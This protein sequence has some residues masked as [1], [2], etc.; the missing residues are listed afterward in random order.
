[1][2]LANLRIRNFRGIAAMDLPLDRHITVIHGDNGAGKTSVL[3][4]I[5]AA[6]WQGISKLH[7]SARFSLGRPDVRQGGAP[8][9]LYVAVSAVADG[10]H[11]FSRTFPGPRGVFRDLG[12]WSDIVTT[13][14]ARRTR[15]YV[16]SVVSGVSRGDLAIEMPIVAYYGTTRAALD[17][18][19][20]ERNFRRE[21]DR[22]GAL[23]HALTAMARFKTV[24]E[25]LGVK[26]AEENAEKVERRDLNYSDPQLAA[27][28]AAIEAAIPRISRLRIAHRPIRL[29]ATYT[30]PG[31]Q[32]QDFEFSQLAGGYQTAVALVADLARRMVQ[33]NPHLGTQSEAI[34]LIDEVD[35]HL[36]PR[37]QAEVMPSLRRAFPNAQFIV[38]THSEQ[39]IT[40][41]Q[42][43]QVVKLST[44]ANGVTWSHPNSTYGAEA[45]RVLQDQMDVPNR[46]TAVQ[47]VLDQYIALIQ[48]GEYNSD[49]ALECRRQLDDWFRGEDPAMV[50]A[51]LEIRRHQILASRAR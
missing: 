5:A 23:E 9:T 50:R 1:M 10:S 38:T 43:E 29:M 40:S 27:V 20:S 46:Q 13:A 32:P 18:P 2:I 34:V 21:F 14:D 4:A 47:Q 15:A 22:L 26:E 37:W 24:F 51:D 19:R 7:R 25:W 30:A 17:L 31:G 3:D 16:D 33:G 12:D 11:G 8:P 45:N 39:V 36:H 41:V 42:P 48:N 44:G 6:V 35:L 28:R 49:P